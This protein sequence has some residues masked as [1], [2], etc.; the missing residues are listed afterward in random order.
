MTVNNR[1]FFPDHVTYLISFLYPDIL[2]SFLISPDST[3][4]IAGTTVSLFCLHSG[5]LPAA[6]MSWV[7][8]GTTLSSSG[9]ITITTVVLT[10]ANPPQTSSSISMSPVTMGDGGQYEC[11][12]TNS[13]LPGSPIRSSMATLTVSGMKIEKLKIYYNFSFS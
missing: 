9:T 3:D 13:L 8:D 5:S 2:D 12:A 7:K 4:S 10:H 11:V 1:L 6:Q